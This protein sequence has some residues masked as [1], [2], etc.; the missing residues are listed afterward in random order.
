MIEHKSV[1]QLFTYYQLL[2]TVHNCMCY[3]CIEQAAQ[4]VCL[5]QHYCKHLSNALLYNII[6]A[7]TSLGNKNFSAPF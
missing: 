6:T 4:W 5:Y 7:K 2:C 3:T 1:T